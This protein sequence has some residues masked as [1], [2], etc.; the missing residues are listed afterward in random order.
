MFHIYLQYYFL[1][2]ILNLQIKINLS[3]CRR[4]AIFSILSCRVDISCSGAHLAWLASVRHCSSHICGGGRQLGAAHSGNNSG[5]LLGAITRLSQASLLVSYS[6]STPWDD[7]SEIFPVLCWTSPVY[8]PGL[9]QL[10]YSRSTTPWTEH[11][12]Q[13][14][15]VVKA[16]IFKSRVA[17]K[18]IDV[19]CNSC[20]QSNFFTKFAQVHYYP[21]HDL[22]A[23]LDP[24]CACKRARSHACPALLAFCSKTETRIWRFITLSVVSTSCHRCLYTTVIATTHN[25]RG[26]TKFFFFLFHRPL[27]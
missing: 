7:P 6:L 23:F 18:L 11:P 16:R 8:T 14:R 25:D 4:P 10:S 2:S 19:Y 5:Q 20:T 27:K 3:L 22:F 17:P 21:L 26:L 13:S 12:L 9:A 15:E 24:E 1:L